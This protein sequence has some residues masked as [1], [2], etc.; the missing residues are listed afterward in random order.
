M[1][2]LYPLPEE[3]AARHNNSQIKTD[4]FTCSSYAIK[5]MLISFKVLILS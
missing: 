2:V 4:S 1:M 5:A 3:A